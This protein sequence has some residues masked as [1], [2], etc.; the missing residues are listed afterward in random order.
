VRENVKY[1]KCFLSRRRLW[2]L[3]SFRIAFLQFGR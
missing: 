3:L 2:K 1:F